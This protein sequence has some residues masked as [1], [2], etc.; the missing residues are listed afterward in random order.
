[1]P[2]QTPSTSRL[3]YLPRLLLLIPFAALIWVPFYNRVEPEL[4]GVPFFYWYQLA[5]I[6]I[7][8]AL[9]FLVYLIETALTHRP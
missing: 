3:R 9:V 7:G 6:L 8:A 1:M 4:A 5:W 2:R